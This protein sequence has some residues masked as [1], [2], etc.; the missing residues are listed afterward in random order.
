MPESTK[1]T[2]V[3]LIFVRFSIR[4]Q[5]WKAKKVSLVHRLLDMTLLERPVP[6][7]GRLRYQNNPNLL[8]IITFYT[9]HYIYLQ[10]SPNCAL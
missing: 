9:V 10:S 6:L 2:I 4:N 7:L 3:S 1:I 8:V 5:R